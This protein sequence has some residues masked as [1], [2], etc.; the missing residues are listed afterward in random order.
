M[1]SNWLLN[2]PVVWMAVVIPYLFAA[3]IH[4]VVIRLATDERGRAF[5]ALS[6]GMLPP[7]GIISLSHPVRK[8]RLEIIHC[9]IHQVVASMVMAEGCEI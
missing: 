1:V 8:E 5:K 3:A 6:P 4:W 9:L 7:L 2:L